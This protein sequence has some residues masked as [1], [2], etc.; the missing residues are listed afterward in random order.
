M[1]SILSSLRSMTCASSSSMA[2]LSGA[3]PGSGAER[4]VEWL[5]ERSSAHLAARSVIPTGSSRTR[6]APA[7]LALWAIARSRRGASMMTGIVLK[8]GSLL[9]YLSSLMP[10]SPGRYRPHTRRSGG[11]EWALLTASM[12]SEQDSV[13][14]PSDLRALESMSASSGSL[15]AISTAR[16]G[17]AT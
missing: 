1:A 12:P 10:P 3:E 16:P 17:A 15:S 9:R 6:S 7:L 8:A 11:L 13:V 5:S 2:A 4:F 14:K